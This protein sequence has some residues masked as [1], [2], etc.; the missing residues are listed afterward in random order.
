MKLTAT[1]T[2]VMLNKGGSYEEIQS[3]QQ[4]LDKIGE[5]DGSE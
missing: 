3:M 1:S 5:E 4:I 2:T